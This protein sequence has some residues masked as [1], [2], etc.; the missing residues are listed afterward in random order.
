MTERA[1][2]LLQMA[3]A[4][5]SELI[6]LLSA[7]GQAA[8]RRP[9]PGREKLGDGTVAA[10]ASHTANNYLRIAAFLRD[11]QHASPAQ[12]EVGSGAHRMPRLLRARGHMG[13]HTGHGDPYRADNVDL[14]DLLERLADA[15]EALSVL[16]DLTELQLD[17]VAP[18]GEMK[19]CDGQRTLE[20]IVTSL[21]VHQRH[22]VDA[23][24]AAVA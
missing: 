7:Q 22:Q 9:C 5:L 3:D 2:Q 20:Q 16:G 15:R 14:R 18:A 12:V 13:G 1:T 21:L 11:E 10:C 19:F 4:Q 6:D 23:L 24:C 8:L 17:S